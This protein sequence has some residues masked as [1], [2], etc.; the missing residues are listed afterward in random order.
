MILILNIKELDGLSK[1]KSSH[2][3]TKIGEGFQL[4]KSV[5]N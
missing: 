2:T 1:L 4:Y 5:K 3:Q